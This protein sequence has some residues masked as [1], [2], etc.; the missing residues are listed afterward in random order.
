ML[1][2]GVLR[3]KFRLYIPLQD[4]FSLNVNNF[5][6]S[7]ILH[8]YSECELLPSRINKNSDEIT[9]LYCEMSNIYFSNINES[10]K[11]FVVMVEDT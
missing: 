8:V 4:I 7:S 11:R 1:S 9:C 3:R 6:N 5:T 10:Y 2:S